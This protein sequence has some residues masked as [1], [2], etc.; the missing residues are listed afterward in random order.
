MT[1]ASVQTA[2]DSAPLHFW[3]VLLAVAAMFLLA[4]SI[5]LPALLSERRANRRSHIRALRDP[6][7]VARQLDQRRNV[8]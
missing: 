7:V 3:Q 1:I 2:A 4:A 8:R 6:F 5:L